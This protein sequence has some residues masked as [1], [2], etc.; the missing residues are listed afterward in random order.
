MRTINC[1]IIVLLAIFLLTLT[2][3]KKRDNNKSDSTAYAKNGHNEPATTDNDVIN[4]E[5]NVNSTQKDYKTIFSNL[6]KEFKTDLDEI[7]NL[8]QNVSSNKLNDNPELLNQYRENLARLNTS[9]QDKA[10]RL[11]KLTEAINKGSNKLSESEKQSALNTVASLKKQLSNQQDKLNKLNQLINKG[12]PDAKASSENAIDTTQN[13]TTT[14][15]IESQ[16]KPVVNES[17]ECYFTMGTAEELKKHKILGSGF[18]QKT[19]ILQSSS[20]MHT[21]FTKANKNTLNE[22]KL[23]SET[24]KVVTPHDLQSFSIDNG[25]LKIHDQDLFWQQTNY[26]VIQVE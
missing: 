19:K 6:E 9:T 16:A 13:V 10:K 3:C 14:Q 18:L 11:S 5:D 24:A 8:E 22:I 15:T 4:Y 26:L 17:S 25:V 7:N 1:H 20:I 2:C 23:S 12:I 21:Y